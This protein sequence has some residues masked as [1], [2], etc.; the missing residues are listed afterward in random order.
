MAGT[1]EAKEAKR[2]ENGRGRE[3]ESDM[4]KINP[5]QENNSDDD[6]DRERVSESDCGE[7]A[8]HCAPVLLLQAKRNGKQPAHGRVNAVKGTQAKEGKPWPEVI[9]GKQ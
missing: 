9:H 2:E 8:E 3:F 4:R 5:R 7:S 6:C 1:P